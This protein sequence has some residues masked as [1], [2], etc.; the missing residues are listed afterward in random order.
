MGE[1]GKQKGRLIH[2]NVR[3]TVG[4]GTNEGENRGSLRGK[5]V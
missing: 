4:D 2:N 3:I 5:P 1:E